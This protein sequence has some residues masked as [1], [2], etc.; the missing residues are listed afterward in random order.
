MPGQSTEARIKRLKGVLNEIEDLPTL[1][2]IFQKLIQILNKQDTTSEEV[3]RIITR[4][5]SLTAKILQIA[6][7]PYYGFRADVSSAEK[8]V[9]LLGF[10]EI[11]RIVHS[12]SV[13]RLLDPDNI[14][15]ALDRKKL[16]HFLAGC[17]AFSSVFAEHMDL[18]NPHSYFTHGL[19]HCI[20]IIALEKHLPKTF[21]RILQIRDQQNTTLIKAEKQVITLSHC[22]ITSWLFEKWNLPEDLIE[23]A[24]Y[25]KNPFDA[26]E[27]PEICSLVNQASFFARCLQMGDLG[28][29]HLP[30]F[31]IYA[32]NQ[33]TIDT[34]DLPEIFQE[35]ED[36][37]NEAKQYLQFV[38]E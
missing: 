32:W 5:P 14:D 2:P 26:E 9:T 34:E 22:E 31:S 36:R 27:H 21:K 1:S 6:N 38:R 23:V 19:L 20:G 10:N 18:E 24:R 30:S 4:D 16:W 17:G 15:F 29:P 13:F 12:I 37:F 35:A 25:H 33:L 28:N 11:K 7:S 3:S 8:A